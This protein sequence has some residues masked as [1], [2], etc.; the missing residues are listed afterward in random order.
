MDASQILRRGTVAAMAISVLSAALPSFADAAPWSSIEPMPQPRSAPG[1]TSLKNGLIYVVGGLNASLVPTRTLYAYNAS[2]DSW[3]QKTSAPVALNAPNVVGSGGMLYVLGSA[4]RPRAAYRYNPSADAWSAVLAPTSGRT[5]FVAGV[6]ASGRLYAIGGSLAGEDSYDPAT[7]RWHPEGSPLV[8]STVRLGDQYDRVDA[9]SYNPGTNAFAKLDHVFTDQFRPAIRTGPDGRVYL[10]GGACACDPQQDMQYSTIPGTLVLNV[11]AGV[12]AYAQDMPFD[13]TDS[14]SAV[15][16]GKLYVFGGRQFF[17]QAFPPA[18]TPVDDAAAFTP[19]DT[20]L[21]VVTKAP[22]PAWSGGLVNDAAPVRLSWAATDPGGIHRY[23]V[24]ERTNGGA[25]A[26]PDQNV[27]PPWATSFDVSLAYGVTHQFRMQ[28]T[29]N[30][31]NVGTWHAGAAFSVAKTEDAR[32]SIT[33]GG[34]WNVDATSAFASLASG[35]ALH[36]SAATGDSA[37]FTFTGSAV[38]FAAPTDLNAG[39]GKV[40]IYVDGTLR[41]TVDENRPTAVDEDPF[42]G[43]DVDGSSLLWGTSWTTT[44]THSVRLVVAGTSGRPRVNVDAFLV[45]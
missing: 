29:D 24:Q 4:N 40:R 6:G 20:T 10:L 3:T 12:A 22:A 39:L 31:A 44:G 27:E 41:A 38:G 19:G 16:G 23:A 21:P 5:G 45:R 28:A 32:P 18:G 2:T 9:V 14:A 8:D 34:S 15:L 25:W 36:D 26:S 11:P 33:Y 17:Y 7:G 1:A 13:A 30:Y 43:E 42:T 35:G 37:R